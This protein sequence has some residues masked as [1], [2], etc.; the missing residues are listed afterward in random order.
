[1]HRLASFVRRISL[2]LWAETKKAQ[3]PLEQTWLCSFGPPFA[4]PV[5]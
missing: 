5:V 1:M 3:D 4:L 2:L